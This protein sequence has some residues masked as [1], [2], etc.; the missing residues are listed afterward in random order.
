MAQTKEK[1][2]ALRQAMIEKGISGYI[3]PS[4]DPHMSEYLPSYY[5]AR[6]WFSGFNGSAGTLV[7]TLDKAALWTDGRYFIQAEH[8]LAGSGIELMRMRVKGTPEPEVWLTENLPTESIMGFDGMVVS[9]EFIKKFRVECSKKNISLLSVDLVTPLWHNRPALPETPAWLLDTNYA[10]LSVAE[11]LDQLRVRLKEKGADSMLVSRLDSVAWL[12]NLRASDIPYNPFALAY[13]LVLPNRTILFIN[14]AR[15]P[16][17]A[18]V[19][20]HTQ[21]VETV[22]YES[23]TETIAAID[24]PSVFLCETSGTN[25]TLFHMLQNN[26][27]VRVVEGEEPIQALKGVKNEKEIE[28]T[29][30]SHVKDGVAMTRFAI[31]LEKVVASG[32][33]VTEYDISEKLLALRLEQP[34]SLG[35]SFETIAAYGPNAAMMHYHPTIEKCSKLEARGFLLADCG[36]QY[37]DGTTDITRTYALGTLTDMEREYYTLVLKSHINLSRAIFLEGCTG[38]NLDI[39]ARGTLW[40]RGIDYRCGTG[41]G[42]G[43]VGAIHEGPQDLRI[44]NNVPFEVGMTITNEPGIYEEGIVGIRIENEL[45]CKEWGTTEYGRFLCFEP[46]TYCPID[47]TPVIVNMLDNDELNWLNN[48]HKVVYETLMPHLN[49]GERTWLEQACAPIER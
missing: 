10:G 16:E 25:E 23:I 28:N 13:C 7:V 33:H 42:V 32:E 30:N 46:I 1:I 6:S 45:L 39:L 38:G 29:I 49:E 15:L 24:Q 14:T 3:I 27:N 48:Y 41:H 43:F 37:R 31:W 19:E 44:T 36:G 47:T 34:E 17:D 11:K 9:A 26:P 21:G 40:Q 2:A 5:E 4:S 20:L 18:Q 12:L 8:Q 35:A 22:V